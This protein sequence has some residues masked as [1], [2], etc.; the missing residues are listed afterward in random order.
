M[1]PNI[2]IALRWKD[3][4]KKRE[5]DDEFSFYFVLVESLKTLNIVTALIIKFIKA[6][7]KAVTKC[8]IRSFHSLVHTKHLSEVKP[9]RSHSPVNCKLL[10][11]VIISANVFGPLTSQFQFPSQAQD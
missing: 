7:T 6:K 9:P 5:F 3:K 2:M 11:M 4:T 8:F 10:P 1:W